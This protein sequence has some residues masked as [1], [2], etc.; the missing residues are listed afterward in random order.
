M[1]H[2]GDQVE[3]LLRDL[4]A[5]GPWFAGFYLVD[6]GFDLLILRNKRQLKIN[7]LKHKNPQRPNITPPKLSINI[8][9][10]A[11]IRPQT[12]NF[13]LLRFLSF[14]EKLRISKIR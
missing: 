9:F 12:T 3:E 10:R 1:E 2:E 7:H 4:A 5:D 13:F 6:H 11:N 14:N 8:A